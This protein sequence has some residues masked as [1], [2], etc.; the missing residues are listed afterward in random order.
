[1]MVFSKA[2][3]WPDDEADPVLTS[4]NGRYAALYVNAGR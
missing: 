4:I 3:T 2:R 1:M